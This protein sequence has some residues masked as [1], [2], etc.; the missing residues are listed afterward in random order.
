M[1][2][3]RTYGTVCPSC[4]KPFEVGKIELENGAQ[5]ADLRRA[6]SE[7]KWEAEFVECPECKAGK[8]CGPSDLIFLDYPKPPQ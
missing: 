6:L 5:L 2:K 8:L 3:I 1:P 7:L 4:K